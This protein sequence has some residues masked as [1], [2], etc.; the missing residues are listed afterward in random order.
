MPSPHNSRSALA[1]PTPILALLK[2][3]LRH[4]THA[5]MLRSDVPVPLSAAGLKSPLSFFLALPLWPSITAA[6]FALVLY[7]CRSLRSRSLS[8]A[9]F[10]PA[11]FHWLSTLSLALS[12]IVSL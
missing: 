12:G 10:P 7:H 9:L 6:L 5:C 2:W 1:S 4:F 3:L 11:F 8:L